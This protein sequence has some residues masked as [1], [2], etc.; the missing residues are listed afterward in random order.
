M[1]ELGFPRRKGE[2]LALYGNLM[3]VVVLACLELFVLSPCKGF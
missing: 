2:R 1:E 3:V